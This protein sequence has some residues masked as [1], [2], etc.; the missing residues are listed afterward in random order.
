M[1][2]DVVTNRRQRVAE[3]ADRL[4]Q[5][6]KTR[7]FVVEGD[8]QLYQLLKP[9]LPGDCSRRLFDSALSVLIRMQMVVR[10]RR[11]RV[12]NISGEQPGLAIF[13]V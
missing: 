1:T 13:L 12:E 8:S 4:V 7:S 3:V 5:I 9:G 2:T 6:L 11:G 10:R